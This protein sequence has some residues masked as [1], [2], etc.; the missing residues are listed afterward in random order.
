MTQPVSNAANSNAAQYDSNVI[1]E[2]P[3]YTED[4]NGELSVDSSGPPTEGQKKQALAQVDNL[5]SEGLVS[6]DEKDYLTA[7]INGDADFPITSGALGALMEI[8]GQALQ[9]DAKLTVVKFEV[10]QAEYEA[11]ISAAE[12]TLDGQIAGFAVTTAF[13]AMAFGSMAGKS[14]WTAYKNK[15]ID[16][17]EQPPQDQMMGSAIANTINQLGAGASGVTTGVQT[18]EASTSQAEADALAAIEPGINND[19]ARTINISYL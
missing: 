6:K 11:K 17:K 12:D 19:T 3:V 1:E 18:Y 2:T 16:P 9:A 8:M 13:S 5:Y 7:V 15:G 10:Q 4:A 14:A